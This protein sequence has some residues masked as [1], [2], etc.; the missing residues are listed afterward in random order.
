MANRINH[1]KQDDR[2]RYQ[3]ERMEA[4]RYMGSAGPSWKMPFGLYAGK[5]L[6]EIPMEYLVR[7][8]RTIRAAH[9]LERVAEEIER[10]RRIVK[11]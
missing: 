3:Q 9:I 11:T 2:V 4:G 10:R 5:A 6:A 7:I 8:R 1:T